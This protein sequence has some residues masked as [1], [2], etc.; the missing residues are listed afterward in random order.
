ML[1]P[2]VRSLLFTCCLSVVVLQS[3]DQT[4]RPGDKVTLDCRLG[5]GSSM[6]SYT[7]LWYRQSHQGAQIEFLTKEY[8]TTGRFE[9]HFNTDKTS[10]SL[11]IT[12]LLLNDSSTYYCAAR[13]S[14]T[15]SPGSHTN[16]ATDDAQEGT[17]TV[18]KHPFCFR[19]IVTL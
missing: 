1:F 4:S 8:E 2:L 11:Q 9:P 3:G 19:N 14:D 12:K 17:Q 10:F 16:K 5:S 15:H 6:N 7:M 18:Q 13:H